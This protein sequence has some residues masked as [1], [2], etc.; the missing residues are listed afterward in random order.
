MTLTQTERITV[1]ITTHYI[2]EARQA[3]FVGLMRHG[4]LLAE[5]TPDN[6]L[7]KY[8]METLEDVFLK[9][10][11][12]DSH[13]RSSK[14]ASEANGSLANVTVAPIN[15]LNNLKSSRNHL[16]L[17]RSA[18]S[19]DNSFANGNERKNNGLKVRSIIYINS[20]TSLC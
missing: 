12:S 2:E 20:E 15:T 6:L 7:Q 4:R 11:M 1:I 5:D 3:S 16:Q 14:L 17:Q 13:Q 18:N 10:C 8:N 19:D 9:L